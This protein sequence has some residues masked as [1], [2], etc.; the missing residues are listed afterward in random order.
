MPDACNKTR[1]VN[2]LAAVHGYRSYLEV[3]TAGTGFRYAEIDRSRLSCRRLSY[4]TPDHHADGHG[5]DYRSTGRDIGACLAQIDQDGFSF[6]IALVDPWHEYKTSRRDLNEAFRRLPAG[7]CLVVH[8]CLPPRAE[9][10]GPVFRE[11]VWCGVTYQAYVDFVHGRNDL[12]FYTVDCD[13]GCGVIRKKPRVDWLGARADGRCPAAAAAGEAAAPP[14]AGGET[15]GRRGSLRLPPGEP[16]EPAQSDLDRRVSRQGK[17][18][19]QVSLTPARIRQI[20]AKALR[21]LKHPSR[22]R[23]L[24]SFLDN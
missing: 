7:G 21:K 9:V 22:S 15:S 19:P 6:D 5:I 3:C 17:T 14:M 10:A 18:A 24:R 4:L 1:I 11:G 23:K 13:Y 16:R 2:H 8:D 20:E 12:A